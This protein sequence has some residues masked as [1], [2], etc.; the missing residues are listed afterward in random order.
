MKFVRDD[1]FPFCA[2]FTAFM[3]MLSLENFF[4]PKK[5]GLIYL[6]YGVKTVLTGALIVAIWGRLPSFR[7]TSPWGS[8]GVGSIVFILWVF[9]DPYLP[10][11]EGF[12]HFTWAAEGGF[13]EGGFRPWEFVENFYAAILVIA[14]RVAGAVLV[15]PIVEE[16]FWRGW[17]QR[18]LINE[19]FTSVRIGQFTPFSFALVSV[20]FALVHPQVFVALFAGLLF[21]WW[22]VKT[23]SLWDVVVSHA[24]AN[25]LLA[26]YVLWS[27]RWYLW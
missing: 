13:R 18:W 3:A 4:D 21:G 15:V 10:W 17:L 1:W 23:K 9:L 19:N 27:G 14:L 20:M 22:V 8:L 2:P 11:M 7:L 24:V 12:F 25:L 16:L 6:L 5:E 26:G